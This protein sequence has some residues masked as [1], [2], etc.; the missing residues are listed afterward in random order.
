LAAGG[1]TAATMEA[2][3]RFGDLC[4]VRDRRHGSAV[5]EFGDVPLVFGAPAIAVPLMTASRKAA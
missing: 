5:T 2:A 1:V 4:G 3:N